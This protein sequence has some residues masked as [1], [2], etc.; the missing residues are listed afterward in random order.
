VIRGE[1]TATPGHRGINRAKIAL[2]QVGVVLRRG[3]E[4]LGMLGE[5]ASTTGPDMGW[6]LRQGIPIDGPR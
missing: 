2:P 5:C 3:R 1:R 4:L 6:R